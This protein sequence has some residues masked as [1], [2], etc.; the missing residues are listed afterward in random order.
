MSVGLNDLPLELLVKITD[1]LSIETCLN[2]A[3]VTPRLA[4]A[5][6]RSLRDMNCHIQGYWR[7]RG[8]KFEVI[9]ERLGDEVLLASNTD[10]PLSVKDN[11]G[12]IFRGEYGAEELIPRRRARS[13]SIGLTQPKSGADGGDRNG[14]DIDVIILILETTVSICTIVV[15]A[16]D[17]LSRIFSIF[18]SLGHL[19]ISMDIGN[20]IQ[21]HTR[22][23]GRAKTFSLSF[24]NKMSY[25]K[26]LEW[27]CEAG[28]KLDEIP[29]GCSKI[30]FTNEGNQDLAKI[31][32]RILE[33]MYGPRRTIFLRH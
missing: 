27:D 32:E 12:F 14:A 18:H 23:Q 16:Y 31:T 11:M 22:M 1:Y 20:F 33:K 21:D 13:L 15:C 2:L 5:V 8:P 25:I 7:E 10:L 24:L 4:A 6:A 19:S 9:F 30:C 28:V 17:E 3:Q 26:M 29:M